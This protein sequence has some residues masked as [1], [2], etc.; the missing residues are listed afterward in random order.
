MNNN[1]QNVLITGATSG[2]GFELAK[3]FATNG[4]N[5]VI[6]ARSHEGLANTA[7]ELSSE[8]GVT[9]TPIVMDLFEKDA[10]REVYEIVLE[11]GIRID[12]LVNDAGQGVYGEFTETDLDREMDIIQ[13]N[14]C[15]LVGFTKYF[16]KDMVSRSNGKILNVTSIAGKV[17]GPWHSV[18]HATKA[19]AH[20]FTEAIREE[21][22]EKGI[23]VTSL[24]PGATQ[25]DF[26]NKAGM[27]ASKIVQ[28]GDLANPA[29]VAK[30]GY[31]ALMNGDDMVVSGFGNKMQVINSNIM[32]DALVAASV[33]KMQAPVEEEDEKG[34]L[35]DS[36]ASRN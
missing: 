15:S 14:I 12:I 24:L 21:V 29:D 13:L 25:T 33:R 36:L 8:F 19:F 9:V 23:V 2:I 35:A 6:V 10:A 30:D 34:V 20:S 5:L 4:Y 7:S 16:L 32:P 31:E 18:Y 17:P 27:N 3:I 1:Q 26:F 11:K 22:R 28:E